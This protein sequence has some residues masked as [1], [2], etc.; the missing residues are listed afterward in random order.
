[1]YYVV[2]ETRDSMRKGGGVCFIKREGGSGH[3]N[4][5]VAVVLMDGGIDGRFMDGI[6]FDCIALLV[7]VHVV[8]MVAGG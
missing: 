7:V 5:R 4:V 1:V 6:T 2:D 8:W 3:A